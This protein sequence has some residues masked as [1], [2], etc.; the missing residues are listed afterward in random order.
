MASSIAPIYF[1]SLHPCPGLKEKLLT[2]ESSGI[3]EELLPGPMPGIKEKA[4]FFRGLPFRFTNPQYSCAAVF[5][6]LNL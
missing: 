2:T 4:P 5:T 1:L 3:S 6:T